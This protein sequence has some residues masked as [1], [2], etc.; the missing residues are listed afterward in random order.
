[1]VLGQSDIHAGGWGI[2]RTMLN[3]IS[4]YTQK[5]FGGRTV[6]FSGRGKLIKTS[7]DNIGESLNDIR[8]WKD[9]F[10]KLYMKHTIGTSLVVH[11][12]RLHTPHAGGPGSIPGQGTR[13]YMPQLRPGA[14]K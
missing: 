11:W 3:A 10:K 13:S 1:M 4:Q 8:V 14:A 2:Q 9:I 7:G 5:S 6:N 12:T